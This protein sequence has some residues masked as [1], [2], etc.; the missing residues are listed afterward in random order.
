MI[1]AATR[2]RRRSLNGLLQ[3]RR[4]W[5]WGPSFSTASLVAGPVYAAANL[6]SIPPTATS[7]LITQN[8]T[9]FRVLFKNSEQGEALAIYLGRIL[10]Q[11]RAFSSL[12]SAN[13]VRSA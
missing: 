6:V 8:P 10:G 7:D 9:T 2:E 13:S 12:T 4:S 1:G 3:V 11:R 5:C